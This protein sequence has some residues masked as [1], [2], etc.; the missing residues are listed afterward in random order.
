MKEKP[1]ALKQSIPWVKTSLISSSIHSLLKIS[2]YFIIFFTFLILSHTPKFTYPLPIFFTKNCSNINA[3][4]KSTSSQNPSHFIQNQTKI[5]TQNPK[6]YI[7]KTHLHHIVFGIASSA[8]LWDQRKNYTKLWWRPNEMRGFA[9]LDKTVRGSTDSATLPPVKISSNTSRFKYVNKKGD[10]SAIRITRIV[11][12]IVRLGLENVRWIVMGDDDTFFVVDNLVRVLSKYDHNQFYYIGS[13][14]ESHL[15][16]INFSYNMG[17][18]GGGFAISYALA[19]TLE[20]MQDR[21]I[22]RYPKLYGSDDRIQACMAE[23]GVPLTKEVGFHQFDI[24]GNPLGLLAA[25]PTAPLVSL[26]HL[27]VIEPIFP[28]MGRVQALQRLKMAMKL[29]SAGL[30]Q[31]S[32]CYDKARNWTASISWGYSAQIYPGFIPAREMEIPER[33]F[34]NWYRKD[35]GAAFSFNTRTL[36]RDVCKRPFVYV[37][38]NALHN[39]STNRT[40]SEYVRVSSS[41]SKCSQTKI[42]DPSNIRIVEVHKRPDPNL[43]DKPPRRNCC[44]VLPTK[45]EGTVVIDVDACKESETIGF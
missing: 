5:N 32:I 16:N 4:T 29:D 40:E 2:I 1:K 9:W 21:C 44:R 23:L 25:H 18:G 27:D 12:E 22:R 6:P 37:L 35:D 41:K 43:W 39:P 14:S 34:V 36:A 24:Y 3:F 13:S 26:H 10:R 42:V 31:Q 20:K 33:T 17:Y 19:K 8:K 30:M 7:E 15:Q 28:N 45:E 11:S 38:S